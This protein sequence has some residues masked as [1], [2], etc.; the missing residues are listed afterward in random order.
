MNETKT[1]HMNITICTADHEVTKRMDILFVGRGSQIKSIR[2]RD[3]RETISLAAN[4]FQ[5]VAHPFMISDVSVHVLCGVYAADM[6]EGNVEI[7]ETFVFGSLA[8]NLFPKV[9]AAFENAHAEFE[10]RN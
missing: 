4:A 8:K 1:L 7:H 5:S 2:G 9:L 10:A 3:I 6:N